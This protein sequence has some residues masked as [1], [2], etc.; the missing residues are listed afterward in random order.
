MERQRSRSL[1]RTK[2]CDL[3]DEQANI[4]FDQFISFGSI[5]RMTLWHMSP[6]DKWGS[7]NSWR[8][9]ITELL[10]TSHGRIP[11][12][13]SLHMQLKT[14][15]LQHRIDS[16]ARDDI[17]L[18]VLN[19]RNMLSLLLS[20][21][22]AP[23]GRAPRRYAHLQ[24]LIDKMAL[25]RDAQPLVALPSEADCTCVPIARAA[26]TTD[27]IEISDASSDEEAFTTPPPRGRTEDADYD[28]DGMETAMFGC[29]PGRPLL[30]DA[31]GDDLDELLRQAE[32][33]TA[34]TPPPLPADYTRLTKK[35]G[36]DTPKKRPAAAPASAPTVSTFAPM[37]A[38]IH[39]YMCADADE[40][41]LWKRVHSKF[42]HDERDRCAN[43]GLG[44]IETRNRSSAFAARGMERW[45]VLRARAS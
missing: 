16:W 31:A 30:T 22:R 18:A 17:D 24:T 29:D 13:V 19:L 6:K 44:K 5:N 12:Q 2:G 10:E 40:L 7:V 45:K 14:W 39:K 20:R 37:D 38:V 1:Q 27:W 36:N 11:N 41:T 3:K 9:F 8:H 33:T 28:F 32:A 42:W 21:K 4:L 43:L 25:D 23:D 34:A 15:L 26:L 35:A